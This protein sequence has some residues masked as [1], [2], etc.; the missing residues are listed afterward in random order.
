MRSEL[1]CE[2]LSHQYSHGRVRAFLKRGI[3]FEEASGWRL[4]ASGFR[5]WKDLREAVPPKTRQRS[6]P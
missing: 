2:L 5:V 3:L 6:C 4:Q 1:C